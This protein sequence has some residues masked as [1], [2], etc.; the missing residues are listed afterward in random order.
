ADVTVTA[1]SLLGVALGSG[2]RSYH[3]SLTV[4]ART[5]QT[6]NTVTLEQYVAGVVPAESPASWGTNGLAALEAQA[7]AARSYAL[8][9]LAGGGNGSICDTTACQVYDG[10][11]D[12]AGT[13]TNSLYTH[14]S[15]QAQQATAGQIL[16]CNAG[17]ACGSPGAVAFTEF[18]SSTGGYTA[19]G[20]FPAVPDDG[21]ATPS[22]PN[23]TWVVSIP[24]TTIQAV[25]PSIG[26]LTAVTVTARNGL[27]DLGGRAQTVVVAGTAGSV[28]V[29]GDTFSAALGL[30]SDWYSTQSYGVPAGGDNGYWVAGA[31]GGVSTFG[32]AGSFGSL[33]GVRLNA[34]VV[35]MAPSADQSGYWL[36][37]GDGGIFSFG[38]AGFYGSTGNIRLA[39]PVLGLAPT[40]S[41]HGYW[42]YASD[43][44]VFSF[45]D[46]GFYG[47]TGNIRLA[48]PVVGM[49]STP[50]GR[51]YWL[52]AADGG[53][54]SFG[55][56]GFYGSTGNIRL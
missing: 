8:A 34:P 29:S 7:V 15:D 36:V 47:S 43:G 32:G 20:R 16:T 37:G 25:W 3:G 17:T 24:A 48:Q 12:A 22:N 39:R 45:G 26:A 18:S 46:A 31:S 10:D 38:D 6:W 42:L 56:A 33:A 19:G 14:Y 53:V 21:D 50:S 40:G 41:G 2:W 52:V 13:P 44:G 28:T 5:N 11:Q 27:G 4:K 30:R 1:S 54:F 51:G 9:Y 55:D 35:S 49:A 23:H